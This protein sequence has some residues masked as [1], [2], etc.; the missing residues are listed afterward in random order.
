MLTSL[1]SWV[2]SGNDINFTNAIVEN[3]IDTEN[4]QTHLYRTSE[5]KHFDMKN[6][7]IPKPIPTNHVQI[8]PIWFS[9][10]REEAEKYKRTFEEL[11]ENSHENKFIILEYFVK[12]GYKLL[13]L[14][15]SDG[16]INNSL[17]Q[18]LV[19]Y[20]INQLKNNTDKINY[21]IDRCKEEEFK[22]LSKYNYNDAKNHIFELFRNVYTENRNSR[23]IDELVFK[24][25]ISEMDN[26][27][28]IRT[29]NIVG[30]WNGYT[31]IVGAFSDII[32]EE[33]IIMSSRM[34]ECLIPMVENS[35]K[36]EEEE[37]KKNI[38]N[39]NIS[40]IQNEER[41]NKFL[42]KGKKGRQLTAN[43]KRQE[44]IDESSEIYGGK[45]NKNKKIKNKKTVKNKNKKIKMKNYK[46]N[47]K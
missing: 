7:P 36:M 28:L 33:I 47:K 38:K 16:E 31:M 11:E 46:K 26:K 10:N 17:L 4:I 23:L 22:Y 30:F 40:K 24:E 1:F 45:T 15:K 37:N 6:Y 25:I 5:S 19:D 8:S 13:N 42:E 43:R 20:V 21:F 32:P 2:Y 41:R 34:E 27:N 29:H 18:I 3:L 9:L 35:Q 39:V 44:I 12:S 14:K